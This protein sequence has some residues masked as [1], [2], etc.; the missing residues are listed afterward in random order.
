MKINVNYKLR[1]WDCLLAIRFPVI[2]KGVTS[3]SILIRL[4]WINVASGGQCFG[5]PADGK[6][7]YRGGDALTQA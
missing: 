6:T 5:G 2:G 1:G 3:I 7:G 4:M